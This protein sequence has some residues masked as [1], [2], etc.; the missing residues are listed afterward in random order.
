MVIKK[1]TVQLQNGLN[2]R[3][4]I[5]FVRKASSFDSQINIMKNGTLASGRDMM[6][7]MNI[8]VE[9]GETITLIADGSDE[10]T[11]ADALESF[12]LNKNFSFLTV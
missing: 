9:E 4:T 2:A 12:L 1:I 8:A 5:K 10:Q 3:H 6:G 11:A 7:V